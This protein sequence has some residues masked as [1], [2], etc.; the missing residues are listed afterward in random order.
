MSPLLRVPRA[1]VVAAAPPERRPAPA[2]QDVELKSP[3]GVVGFIVPWNYP[4]NLAITDAVGA[5]MAGNR[6]YSSRL[7]TS[8]TALWRSTCSARRAC[9]P[10]CSRW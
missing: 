8:L 6:R 4:L 7:Q 3:V 1:A 2:D 9:R 5:L 10:M